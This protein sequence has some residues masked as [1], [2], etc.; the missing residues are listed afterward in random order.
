MKDIKNMAKQFF[1]SSYFRKIIFIIIIVA[2]I[3]LIFFPVEYTKVLTISNQETREV[4]LKVA[5]DDGDVVEYAWIHSFEHIPWN[6]EYE[7]EE[8]NNLML[9]K[10]EVAGFGAGIPEDKGKVS[11][12]NGI[13]IMRDINEEFE[14]I[15][16]INSN[17]A[18]K[19]ISL[20]DEEIIKGSDL[21]HHE[22]LNLKVKEEFKI[23]PRRFR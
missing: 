14:E 18:L 9:I 5:V 4:Y 1:V 11:I 3:I 8:S 10:I 19:C 17:T 23:C 22:P 15:N 20:N 16:W 6:E 13:I 2:A 7:I 21:P 12:E